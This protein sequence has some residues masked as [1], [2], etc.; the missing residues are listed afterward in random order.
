MQDWLHLKQCYLYSLV[1]SYGLFIILCVC[2][3][4]RNPKRVLFQALVIT[5]DEQPYM[6]CVCMCVC[7]FL[8]VSIYDHSLVVRMGT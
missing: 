3:C 8:H 6:T 7:V 5:F 2:V 4:Q 1:T